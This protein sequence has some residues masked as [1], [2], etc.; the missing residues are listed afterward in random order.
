M[1]V[2][3]ALEQLMGN[4][5]QLDYA[6]VPGFVDEANRKNVSDGNFNYKLVFRDEPYGEDNRKRVVSL[7]VEVRPET[8]GETTSELEDGSSAYERSLARLDE[9][10]NWLAF[11][12]DTDSLEV[13]RKARSI[14]LERGFSTGWD[15]VSIEFPYEEVILGGGFK[16]RVEGKPRS[17]LGII[18]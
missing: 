6:D 5:Q 18:Q 13:F 12:V 2:G 7:R 3:P 1:H 14:A 8:D 11:G 16:Q 4:T 17:G 15:P 10:R 9:E